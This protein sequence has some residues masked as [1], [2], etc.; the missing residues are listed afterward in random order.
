MDGPVEGSCSQ[1][2]S[3]TFSIHSQG[4][5][6]GFSYQTPQTEYRS[7]EGLLQAMPRRWNLLSVQARLPLFQMALMVNGAV[8]P[9]GGASQLRLS[10]VHGRDK[11]LLPPTL[12]P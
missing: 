12:A 4:L 6:S 11:I 10:Q 1:H 3:T 9:I 5:D 8:L 7:G 2:T